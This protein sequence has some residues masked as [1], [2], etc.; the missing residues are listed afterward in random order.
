MNKPI[1]AENYHP[2]G[3]LL[4]TPHAASNKNKIVGYEMFLLKLARQRSI[5]LRIE[6]NVVKIISNIRVRTY[7]DVNLENIPEVSPALI[8]KTLKTSNINYEDGYTCFI[9]KCMFCN[10]STNTSKPPTAKIYINKTTGW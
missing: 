6:K 1:G 3:G 7:Y 10:K 9:A 5:E 8:K 4:L 2:L